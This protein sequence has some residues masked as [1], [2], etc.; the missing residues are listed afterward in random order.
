MPRRRGSLNFQ[1]LMKI[2]SLLALALASL[3]AF[4]LPRFAVAQDEE[5]SFDFFYENLSPYGE[6]LEVGDYG[7]CWR[8]HGIDEDWA[9][10]SDGYWSYTDGGW[11]WVSYEDFGGIVYHYGRWVKVE[12]EGWC[13]VPDYEWGPAW[14]S[15]RNNDDYVGWAPLPPE[16][17]WRRDTGI[18]VWVDTSYDIGPSYYNFCAVRDFGAPYIRPCIVRRS[19]NVVII[20]NTVNITNITFNT[21][22][23]CVFNT[24]PD[25]TY[26]NRRVQRQIPALKLV[27]QTNINVIN[28]TVINNN[29][30]VVNVNPVLRGNQL[31]VVAP[32]VRHF[33]RD[34]VDRI[35]RPKITKVVAQ[36]RVNRGWNR[37]DS[38]DRDAI[39]TKFR[40]EAKG[41]TPQNAPA[42]PPKPQDIAVVPVKADPNAKIDRPE[43]PDRPD[44]P[45]RPQRPVAETN[46]PVPNP[47]PQIPANVK[48]PVVK[49]PDPRETTK[50][51]P[52][53][54]MTPP[55]AVV[56]TPDRPERPDR[57]NRPDR[58]V[59]MP[60][61]PVPADAPE[62]TPPGRNRPVKPGVTKPFVPGT[63][64]N[65]NPPNVPAP[66][67]N[68]DGPDNGNT[69]IVPPRRNPAAE[70]AEARK[71]AAEAAAAERDSNAARMQQQ[72]EAMKQRQLELQKQKAAE[73]AATRQ[74]SM[75]N[76][77]IDQA[78]KQRQM[79]ALQQQNAAKQRAAEAA[80][81]RQRDMQENAAKQRQLDLQQQ[82]A[83]KQRQMEA[84]QQNAVR[85]REAQQENAARQRNAEAA[86]AARERAQQQAEVRRNSA[87]PPQQQINRQPNVERRGP[88]PNR[89]GPNPEEAE[90]KN[91]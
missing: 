41:L 62:S 74:K 8:P 54:P 16:A 17:R 47:T 61:T 64:D 58:P 2:R 73:A 42:R 75:E 9:P 85:Q 24:G 56:D 67:P 29:I 91:R 33:N 60:S 14:V 52:N 78:A 43:R 51:K 38:R 65:N 13:W 57:P 59:A 89:R 80:A 5:V 48:P 36:D 30:K 37:V 83:V 66:R 87:P 3:L 6:W 72:Q 88:P 27:R 11:T 21:G 18:S 12:D 86:A 81:A 70:A 79:E 22:A 77:Q 69:G 23:G 28:K 82:N 63:A 50:T 40:E 26:I 35:A 46:Q 10:Y 49:R 34:Q 20:R 15:W 4:A 55:P 68:M 25:Y 45:D 84:Q 71:R 19:E 39:R 44:R 32:P 31:V 76:Q 7:T 90:Q 1:P 53:Q